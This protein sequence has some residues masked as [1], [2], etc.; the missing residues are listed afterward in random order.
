MLAR[1]RRWAPCPGQGKPRGCRSIDEVRCMLVHLC[2]PMRPKSRTVAR[3]RDPHRPACTLLHAHAGPG[4]RLR[5]RSG[6]AGAPATRG[7][8]DG[9]SDRGHAMTDRPR[10]TMAI[11]TLD[12]RSLATCPAQTPVLASES[13][14]A[15][16]HCQWGVNVTGRVMLAPTPTPSSHTT[17]GFAEESNL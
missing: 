5:I 10:Q 12:S 13:S 11:T 4:L 2:L 8:R 14:E 3:Q 7:G 17:P 16:C 6:H 15:P 9:W 1:L